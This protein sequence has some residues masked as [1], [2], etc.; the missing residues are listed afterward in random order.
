MLSVLATGTLVSD[1]QRRTSAANKAYAVA[2]L[3]TP[4][5]GGEAVLC[6]LIAFD[7][8]AVDVLLAHSKG[9]A[10]AV[11]GRA[12]LNSWA[13]RDGSEQHGL[14]IVVDR[15]MSAYQAAKQRAAAR[16]PEAVEAVGA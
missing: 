7:E 15:V 11:A 12:K 14:S 16:E 8:N 13:G 9:D 3:R 5:E 10:L 1:P 6:G 2:S 4:T